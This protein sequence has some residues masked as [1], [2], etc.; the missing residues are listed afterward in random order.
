LHIEVK[1]GNQKELMVSVR[2]QKAD[3]KS[4]SRTV[5]SVLLFVVN[6]GDS[7]VSFVIELQ[8]NQKIGSMTR[9]NFE[10][11]E[12]RSIKTCRTWNLAGY[13]SILFEIELEAADKEPEKTESVQVDTDGRNTFVIDASR[14]HTYYREGLNVYRMA[15][16]G[17]SLDKQIWKSIETKPFIEQMSDNNLLTQKDVV[18]RSD[19]GIPKKIEIQYPLPVY[20]RQVVKIAG[21]D[22]RYY[23]MYGRRTFCGTAELLIND[24]LVDIEAGGKTRLNDF[25]NCIQ[26]ITRYLHNGDNS[27]DIRM[28]VCSD[29]DGLCDPLYILGNFY[30]DEQRNS[31]ISQPYMSAMNQSYVSGSPFYSG[32]VC[33]KLKKT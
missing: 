6:H 3:G 11:G 31:I 1:T 13:E 20:Y 26:E 14:E 24:L 4:D 5:S 30:V 9:W 23:L 17:L 8:R 32:T 10:D 19:F 16:F 28:N 2:Y 7:P 12:K 21:M 27:I 25:N 33:W 18:F 15:E 29:S 22:S